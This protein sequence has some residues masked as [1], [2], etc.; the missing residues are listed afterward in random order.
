MLDIAI[1]NKIPLFKD[2]RDDQLSRLQPFLKKVEYPKGS[3]ILRENTTGDNIFLLVEGVA[4]VTK[5]LVMGFDEDRASTEKVLH[6]M[7]S[8]HLPTF[9]ENGILGHAPRTANIIA[10]TDCVLYTLSKEDFDSYAAEDYQAGY[11]LVLNIARVI[12]QRLSNTDINLVK[13][14]TALYIAVRQ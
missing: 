7:R 5:D 11:Y 10:Q 4:V 3:Y 12:S 2:L 9:G 1:L 13:L 8:E 14:A 6:T